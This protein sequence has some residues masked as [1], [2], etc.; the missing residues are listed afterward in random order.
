[1]KI[2]ANDKQSLKPAI[3]KNSVAA[4]LKSVELIELFADNLDFNLRLLKHEN[5]LLHNI[6]YKS[7][8]TCVELTSKLTIL[9][10]DQIQ[11]EFEDFFTKN[12]SCDLT[13]LSNSND[14]VIFAV[15][16]LIVKIKT[17]KEKA[18]CLQ[19]EDLSAGSKLL[20]F[21]MKFN[22][23]SS[24]I[25]SN[26]LETIKAGFVETSEFSND[27]SVHEHVKKVCKVLKLVKK[28]DEYLFE[29]IKISCDLNNL[30]TEKKVHDTSSHTYRENIKFRLNS[31]GKKAQK[32]ELEFDDFTEEEEDAIERFKI[33]NRRSREGT[34]AHDL[35]A[36]AMEIIKNE[37][38]E[39]SREWTFAKYYLLIIEKLGDFLYEE[40]EKL[41]TN[42]S[43]KSATEKI[44]LPTLHLTKNL[45]RKFSDLVGHET[46]QS[47]PQVKASFKASIFLI[48]NFDFILTFTHDIE[49]NASIKKKDA[50]FETALKK[51]IE[52][53]IQK[54]NDLYSYLNSKWEKYKQTDNQ[55]SKYR[56]KEEFMFLFKETLEM[57]FKCLI[58]NSTINENVRNL[59]KVNLGNILE[60]L[61]LKGDLSIILN[62]LHIKND[63]KK[64]Y[65]DLIIE[66]IFP[67]INES[68]MYAKKREIKL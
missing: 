39:H 34:G 10:I 17:L 40:V 65:K 43:A 45:S 50:N 35:E 61:N 56:R 6:Y 19:T 47:F 21:S 66:R 1:M 53:S 31:L 15:I 18:S 4:S 38:F 42:S 28:Y 63:E 24:H 46:S 23:T 58:H 37:E 33:M 12:E 27:C 5:R 9:V 67:K 51:S 13:K 60:D 29:P 36:D 25:F 2:D 54:T 8:E 57:L 3:K 26:Y 52:T 55:S 22:E 16:K 62:E 20:N 59:T 44:G 7:N 48:N 68:T 30:S 32:S 11:K 49:I 14:E 41:M 64:N